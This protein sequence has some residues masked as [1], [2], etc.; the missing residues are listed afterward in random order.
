MHACKGAD[1][2]FDGRSVEHLLET[3]HVAGKNQCITCGKIKKEMSKHWCSQRNL[4]SQ[5]ALRRRKVIR[6]NLVL[7]HP[8]YTLCCVQWQIEVA[9]Y[10]HETETKCKVIYPNKVCLLSVRLEKKVHDGEKKFFGQ[11][12]HLASMAKF[13]TPYNP[14]RSIWIKGLFYTECMF[15]H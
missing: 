1:P 5:S 8:T 10:G 14:E 9:G 7:I 13:V 3:S 11:R 2:T 15:G 12:I 6:F 4:R